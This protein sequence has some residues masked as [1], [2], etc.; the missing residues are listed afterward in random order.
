MKP[1]SIHPIVKDGTSL[2]ARFEGHAILVK[3]SGNLE[4]TGILGGYLKQLHA[5]ALRLGADEV[6]VDC[7][8]LYFMSAACVR[9]LSSWIH[10]VAQTEAAYRYKI[11]LCANPNFL[12]QGRTFESLRRDGPRH[13]IIEGDSLTTRAAPLS[14]TIASSAQSPRTTR[15]PRSATMPQVGAIPET[16]VARRKP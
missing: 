4:S 7:E 16:P 14:G 2:S 8:E 11:R 15:F 13:V 10:K 9:C 1:F 6:V 3:L 5:E 12:W